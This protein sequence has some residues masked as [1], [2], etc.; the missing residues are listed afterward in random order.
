MLKQIEKKHIYNG[1]IAINHTQ[2][3]GQSDKTGMTTVR[4]ILDEIYIISCTLINVLRYILLVSS[5]M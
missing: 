5:F 2:N 4:L 1:Q 3:V